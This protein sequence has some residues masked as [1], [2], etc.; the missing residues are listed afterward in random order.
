MMATTYEAPHRKKV[1][2]DEVLTK[3]EKMQLFFLL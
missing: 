3:A 1:K 2:S